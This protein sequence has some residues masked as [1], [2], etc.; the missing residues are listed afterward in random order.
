MRKRIT[1]GAMFLAASA[2][3]HAQTGAPATASA[4][5]GSSN[6]QPS[7]IMLTPPPVA[8]TS[9][10]L[11]F[12]SEE[13]ANYLRAGIT[14]QANHDDDV[15]TTANGTA[16][17]DWSYSIWPSIAI[18]QTWSRFRWNV[19]YVPGFT[20]YQNLT[21]YNEQDHNL[22][23][24]AEYRISQHVTLGL[25]D[26]LQ[27]TSNIFNQPLL[28]SSGTIGGSPQGPNDSIVTPISN[29]LRN[30]AGATLTY[31]FSRDDMVG[32]GGTATNLHFLDDTQAQGLY[33]G[34]AAGGSVFYSHRF[35]TRHYVG[36]SYLYQDLVTY[37]P[38][39]Q[40]QTT[41]D[42]ILGFYTFYP[43][44]TF[45][46]SLFGGP[47][48]ATSQVFGLPDSTQWT[49][50]AGASIG[51]QG[52]RTSAAASY[53]RTITDGGGLLGAVHSNSGALTI[54]RQLTKSW[55][56]GGLGSYASNTL[57]ELSQQFNDSGHTLSG[58]VWAQR[59]FGQ[60]FNVQVGYAHL[61]QTYNNVAALAAVPGRNREWI[62]A[63]YTFSRPLGR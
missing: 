22:A 57:V 32:I 50:A 37:L 51:W 9:Y 59:D 26:S 10:S 12:V 53:L 34:F 54:R 35:A 20:F 23:L 45:S 39:A 41:T 60:H 5:I 52:Q 16:V 42:T 38:G 58:S 3:S 2:I 21:G 1:L 55:S 28:G 14:F 25:R 61:H 31:Q 11:A 19:A 56:V 15:L 46:F 27:K 48:R 43:R 30:T 29:Q 40:N 18:N 36:V 24:S 49:P 6:G 7:D 33:D 44:R 4:P 47:Q 13:R 17:S 8:G 63:T 62:S